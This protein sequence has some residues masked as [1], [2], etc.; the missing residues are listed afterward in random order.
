VFTVCGKAG[1][2]CSDTAENQSLLERTKI[3]SISN[4]TR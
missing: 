4:K 3:C 2:M 1:V